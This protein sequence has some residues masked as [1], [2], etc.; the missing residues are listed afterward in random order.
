MLGTEFQKLVRD[1][2]DEKIRFVWFDFHAECKNMKYQNLSKLLDIVSKELEGYGYTHFTSKGNNLTKVD[3][4]KGVFRTNCMDCLDRTNVVQS[5]IGRNILHKQLNALGIQ[6][7]RGTT[8]F[9]K[10]PED[11]Q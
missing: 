5:V 11:L 9:E 7:K 1:M 4:Q 10:L 8:A 3:S 2:R 6:S